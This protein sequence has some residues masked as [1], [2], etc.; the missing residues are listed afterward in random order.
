VTKK[1]LI[2]EDEESILELLLAIFDDLVDY[3]TFY[4]RDGEE[5]LRIAR[6]DI[7]DIILLDMQIPKIN[8][9]EV[10]RLIKSAPATSNTKVLMLTGIVQDLDLRKAWQAEAD[11]C[12]TKPFTSAAL[13]EKVEALL[14]Y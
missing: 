5:A 10:C 11:A 9:S 6:E 1:I 4:A 7:P 3:Q 13:L 14:R 8:G 2:V 12:M